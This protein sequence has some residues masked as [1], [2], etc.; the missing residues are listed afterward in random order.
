MSEPQAEQQPT[1][2]TQPLEGLSHLAQLEAELAEARA[3]ASQQRDLVL[4]SWTTSASVQR[5][6]SSR[7][8]V[9]RWKN[10]CR[11][12]CPRWTAWSWR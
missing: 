2:A 4:P 11:S 7:H 12:C 1:D 3:Q 6:M 5:A 10:S 8:T 9:S